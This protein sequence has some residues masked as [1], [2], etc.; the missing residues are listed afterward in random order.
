MLKQEASGG[1]KE[2]FTERPAVSAEGPGTTGGSESRPDSVPNEISPS[3]AGPYVPPPPG[4]VIREMAL[5][6]SKG[7]ERER[8]R[9]GEAVAVRIVVEAFDGAEPAMGIGIVR[10]DLSPVYGITTLIDRVRPQRLKGNYYSI[11]CRFSSPNLLPG[12]YIVRGHCGDSA[13]GTKLYDTVERKMTIVGETAEFGFC[14][15][16]H[17]WEETQNGPAGIRTS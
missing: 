11:L 3:F 14:R 5:L 15:L 7:M 2:A 9:S 17:R 1:S 16:E 12:R 6:D 4:S 13:T 8:F 10:S